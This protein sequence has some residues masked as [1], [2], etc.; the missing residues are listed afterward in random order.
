L[1][2]AALAGERPSERVGV[3]PGCAQV[4]HARESR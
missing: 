4:D 1:R 3:S 2:G